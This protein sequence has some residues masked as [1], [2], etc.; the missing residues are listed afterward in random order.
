MFSANSRAEVVDFTKPSG[1]KST[2]PKL[3]QWVKDYFTKTKLKRQSA[4]TDQTKLPS[5]S[6]MATGGST[7]QS[8]HLASSGSNSTQSSSSSSEHQ[9]PDKK[10][11]KLGNSG[12]LKFKKKMKIYL[13]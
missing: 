4:S 6:S 2:H 9:E 12:K 11:I 3:F 7:T 10:R 5:S 1:N 13:P 8:S